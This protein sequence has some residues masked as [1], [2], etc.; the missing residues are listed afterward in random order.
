MW[1][2]KEQKKDITT[3]VLIEQMGGCCFSWRDT[4]HRGGAIKQTKEYAGQDGTF[5]R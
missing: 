5:P 3:G 2:T 1:R 4:H